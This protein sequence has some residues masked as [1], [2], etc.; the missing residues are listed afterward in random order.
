VTLVAEDLVGQRSDHV[1][2]PS[3]G[4]ARAA[5]SRGRLRGRRP[6]A[7]GAESPSAATERLVPWFPR[8]TGLRPDTCPPHG[9]L[10]IAPSTA[11]SSRFEPDHPVIGRRARGAAVP[12]RGRPGPGPVGGVML[13]APAPATV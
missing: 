5:G 4:G 8:S 7:A 12:G 2:N 3:Q 1:A 11:S 9:D 6:G 13:H 10:V